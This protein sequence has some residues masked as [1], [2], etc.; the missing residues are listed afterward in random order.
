M[1]NKKLI[2]QI[3]KEELQ[4]T[5]EEGYYSRGKS[6]GRGYYRP[7]YERNRYASG[8]PRGGSDEGGPDSM[9]IPDPTE[10]LAEYPTGGP[11]RPHK[12]YS[13]GIPKPELQNKKYAER[14]EIWKAADPQWG[15]WYDKNMALIDRQRA[16]E[17]VRPDPDFRAW[18]ISWNT[19]SKFKG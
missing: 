11:G 12:F 4:N 18:T 17:K 8:H 19:K 9:F 6:S 5:M 16:G 10:S 3:I 14:V 15:A 1:C 7:D 2:L 13:G